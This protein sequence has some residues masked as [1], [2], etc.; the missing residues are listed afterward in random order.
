MPRI[1]LLLFIYYQPRHYADTAIDERLAS[2]LAITP[3]HDT[4]H[5][6][7]MPMPHTELVDIVTS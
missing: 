1:M 4:R 2:C 6:H 3:R 5:I 7:T